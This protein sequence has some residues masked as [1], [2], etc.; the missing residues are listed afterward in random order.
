MASLPKST[1]NFLPPPDGPQPAACFRVIDLGTQDTTYKGE[2]KRQ[3]Q[4]LIGWEIF[5]EE[6][7]TDGRPFTIGRKYTLSTSEKANLRK[8]LE[9]WRGKK[10]ADAEL[11]PGGTFQIESIIGKSCLLNIVHEER[12]GSVYAN[13]KG[14]SRLPK[15]MAVGAPENAT[16][17][18]W[19]TPEDFDATAFDKL[20]DNLKEIIQKS[21]EY[22][23][24]I[25]GEPLPNGNGTTHAREPEFNDDIPF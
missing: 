16:A 3:H 5:S 13:V 18:V 4:I 17:F 14:I 12:D 8:D 19:L 21:P 6:R 22:R 10:F 25:S 15:G 1:T 24:I 2:A 23:A 9:S 20:S 11:G 7:M